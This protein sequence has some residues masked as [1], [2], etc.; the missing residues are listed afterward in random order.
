MLINMKDFLCIFK[1]CY[2][3][4]KL[5]YFAQNC[6]ESKKVSFKDHIQEISNI[7]KDEDKKKIKEKV[8]ETLKIKT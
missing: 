7:D 8:K 6:T 3:C 1:T 4:G 2:N 5:S